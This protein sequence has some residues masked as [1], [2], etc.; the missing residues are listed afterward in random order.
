MSKICIT[1]INFYQTFLSFDGG[2][3]SVLTPGGACRYEITCSE[4]TKKA[5][6]KYGLITGI[7]MGAKR[8]WRCR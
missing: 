2:V 7:I 5:I 4:Y 8:I 6:L 1:L 3:L